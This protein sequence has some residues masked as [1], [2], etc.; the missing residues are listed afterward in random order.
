MK[1]PYKSKIKETIQTGI[2]RFSGGEH[3]AMSIDNALQFLEM[4][5]VYPELAHD[6][7]NAIN[8]AVERH[9]RIPDLFRVIRYNYIYSVYCQMVESHKVVLVN[10]VRHTGFHDGS[11]WIKPTAVETIYLRITSD[12]LI[13]DFLDAP[14]E[15]PS[16][17][18]G[19]LVPIYDQV[20]ASF[21]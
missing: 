3:R 10:I 15:V 2:G 19:N 1:P 13:A 4:Y 9:K 12:G 20:A 8:V 5:C 21:H 11:N 16:F 18:P 14:D 7:R 17:N 6:I